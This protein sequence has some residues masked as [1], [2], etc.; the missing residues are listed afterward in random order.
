MWIFT[1]DGFYSVTR[2]KEQPEK[3]QIRARARKHL[4]ILKRKFK[5]K[6]KI[7][8][9][10]AADYRF[11]IIVG[12]RAAAEIMFDLAYRIDYSNFKG[13][14]HETGADDMPLMQV[15]GLMNRYQQDLLAPPAPHS[16]HFWFD[17]ERHEEVTK[18]AQKRSVGQAV[19]R[20]P[21]TWGP[22][23]RDEIPYRDCGTPGCW[24]EDGHPGACEGNPRFDDYEPVQEFEIPELPF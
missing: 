6:R 1:E 10:P 21:R 17:D 12:R 9:T 16:G 7:L 15:W 18:R 2:S 19:A 13:R 4:E 5:L 3:I 8:E 14:C 22:R 11:R 23:W 24:L 20:D